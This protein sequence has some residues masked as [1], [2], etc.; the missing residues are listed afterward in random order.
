MFIGGRCGQYRRPLYRSGLRLTRD[1]VT[2]RGIF[3][4]ALV[5]GS[6]RDRMMTHAIFNSP[7]ALTSALSGA[8]V[9]V[10]SS[11]LRFHQQ[12]TRVAGRCPIPTWSTFHSTGAT[13]A[14]EPNESAPP[15]SRDAKIFRDEKGVTWWVHE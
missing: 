2:R 9:H 4:L 14:P 5:C 13:R 11:V 10:R 7:T 12:P 1:R 8:C 15:A 6:A 3:C